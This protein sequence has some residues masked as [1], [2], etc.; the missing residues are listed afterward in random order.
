MAE[1]DKVWRAQSFTAAD[2]RPV[3]HVHGE[4]G[5]RVIRCEAAAGQLAHVTCNLE[6]LVR[7]V[8]S[9]GTRVPSPEDCFSLE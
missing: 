8:S 2:G 1:R 6:V 4:N 3:A 5:E 7:S 9:W